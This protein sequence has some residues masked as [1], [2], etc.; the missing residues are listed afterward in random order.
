[1]LKILSDLLPTYGRIY[2]FLHEWHNKMD[3]EMF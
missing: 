1:M 2:S 3:L